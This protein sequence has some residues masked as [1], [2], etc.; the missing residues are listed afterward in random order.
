MK[1]RA[2]RSS[3]RPNN[4][5]KLN[6]N[7]NKRKS[8]RFVVRMTDTTRL[9]SRGG[10]G[11]GDPETPWLGC[12]T[13]SQTHPRP[14]LYLLGANW[15]PCHL[16]LHCHHP[17]MERKLQTK[18]LSLLLSC[19]THTHAHTDRQTNR[20]RQTEKQ[21]QGEAGRPA[22]RQTDRP[23][24]RHIKAGKAGTTRHRS[25]SESTNQ[26]LP[27]TLLFM[28]GSCPEISWFSSTRVCI[29]CNARKNLFILLHG[30]ARSSFCSLLYVSVPQLN[31]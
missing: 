9:L 11:G 2:S 10:G 8:K 15:R 18:K 26:P 14:R 23:T 12:T 30:K 19:I 28:V 6:A 3:P 17:K 13:T 4:E 20:D 25:V 29:I 7:G 21:R 16:K 5:D 24:D 1:T 22:G 27:I 31:I